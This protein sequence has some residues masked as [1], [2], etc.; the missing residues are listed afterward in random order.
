M[1]YPPELEPFGVKVSVIDPGN[2]RSEITANMRD[3][4]VEAG[5]TGKGS[6]Y[7]DQMEGLLKGPTD[8]AQYKEPDEVAEAFLQALSDENPR[9]RYMVVPNQLEAEWTIRAAIG[10]VVQLNRGQP[11]AYDRETLIRLL[12]E[13]LST[14]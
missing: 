3:R 11:Y 4:L 6:L 7:E 1:S 5:Y 12:D 14:Q 13:A 2:Y 9:R 10:R 8:R